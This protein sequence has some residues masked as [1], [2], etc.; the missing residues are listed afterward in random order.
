MPK[1]KPYICPRCDYHCNQKKDMKK[2]F[3]RKT[4]CPDMNN[5]V[6]SPEIMETVLENH[7]YHEPKDTEKPNIIKQTVNNYN[8]LNNFVVKMDTLSK[9]DCLLDY[10]DQP[11][12]G[13]EDGLEKYFEYRINRLDNDKYHTPYTLDQDRLISIIDDVTKIDRNHIEKLNVIFDKTLRRLKVWSGTEW[14]SFLE[15]IGAKEIVSL[16]K[17]YFLDTYEKYLLIKLHGDGQAGFNRTDIVEHLKIYYQFIGVFSLPPFVVDNNDIDILG[18]R[19][20]ECNDNVL[21]ERYMKIYQ[22]EKSNM[23]VNQKNQIKRKVINIIKHNTIHN[24]NE[25]NQI[26]FELAKVNDDFKEVLLKSYQ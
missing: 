9:I 1:S 7:K 12:I 14:E 6:L 24:V 3:A 2:H 13:F 11:L 17:S 16:V 26:I 18:H 5:V 4:S 20:I 19:L 10:K 15:E 23:K 22:E 21:G 25:L 8:I